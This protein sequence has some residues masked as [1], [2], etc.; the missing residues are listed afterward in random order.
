LGNGLPIAAFITTD[1]IA[2]TYTKPG[3]STFGG[4]LVCAQTAQAALSYMQSHQ[5]EQRAAQSG[6]QLLERMEALAENSPMIVEVRGRG[7]ML[8]L[9][10]MDHNGIVAGDLLDELLEWLKDNGLLAGKTG[11]GRNVLT[12]MPPLIISIEELDKL[13]QMVEQAFSVLGEK[14]S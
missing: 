14:Y 8:G 6:Q 13:C 3:A 2:E 4:N 12:L 11:P 7:L 9:E 5:L 10:L 1:K